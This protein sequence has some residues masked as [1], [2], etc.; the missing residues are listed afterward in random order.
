MS[1]EQVVSASVPASQ[2]TASASMPVSQVDS[3]L[4]QAQ[5]SGDDWVGIR[6][7]ARQS[8]IDLSHY[9]DDSQAI[10]ALFQAYRQYPQLQHLARYGQEYLSNQELYDQ[11]R[12]GG[13]SVP[14][15]APPPS[16]TKGW[17][18]PPISYDDAQRLMTQWFERDSQ[19]GQPRPRLDAP[20]SVV[21]KLNDYAA[22]VQDWE[23]KLRHNPAEAF[24]HAVKE[25]A[26]KVLVEKLTQNR[27]A[28]SAVDVIKRH[29]N[30]MFYQDPNSGAPVYGQYTPMG[31][32]F[33][34]HVKS[35]DQA[36]IKDVASLEYFA[37]ALLQ[38]DMQG[39]QTA[40]AQQP[41]PAA[42]AG[43][44]RQPGYQAPAG[45]GVPQGA[46][47]LREMLRQGLQ[48]AGIN[49]FDIPEG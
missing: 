32:A 36:G 28:E 41:V 7:C 6:D 1:E 39:Q 4:G 38:R 30:W 27:A 46:G 24:R 49:N 10:Q 21:Q 19:T 17:W 2:D 5:V 3:G 9:G 42:Q 43:L 29:Q 15:P 31:M 14:R 33:W 18:N 16:E 26:E 44:M 34:N 35:L 22:Y 20:P 37:L 13:G 45:Q 48:A 23:T 25:E 47:G 12:A 40:A 8:G 11:A